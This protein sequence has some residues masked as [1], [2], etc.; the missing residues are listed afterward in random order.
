MVRLISA[1]LCAVL[2]GLT[3]AA[4]Q[5]YPSRPISIIV[6]YTPG[7]PVDQ[8]ARVVTEHMRATLGQPFVVENVSGA[9]GT[10]GVGRVAR[11]TPN[12]YTIG[13][14]DV[15]T[16]V[17]NGAVYPLSYDV[18]TDFEP[19]ALLVASPL[20]VL[21]RSSLPAKTLT[22]LV[23]WLKEN[24]ANVSQGFI[25]SGTLSHLC[26]LYLQQ[27]T[28]SKWT[29]VPYRGAAPA[30]QDLVG[31]QIDVMCLAPSGSSLPLARSGKIRAYAI[32]SPTR[33][34]SAKEIPTADEAGVPGLHLSFWQAL[35]VPKGTPKDI[36]DRLNAAAVVA[37]ADDGV[38]AKLTELG[39][40]IPARDQQTP[41]ALAALRRAEAD[42]W[43]PVIKAAGIKPDR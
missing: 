4:A 33:L 35:W 12:G 39:Q 20:L 38:R 43:W 15:G 34:P 11:A 5:P 17:L 9:G 31:G 37:L 23:A 25:G 8:V 14:G 1:T 29:F 40:I 24:R 19:V 13:I 26:G 6:P 21:S 27:V 16:Q 30:I 7:G 22:E 28:G 36:I 42:K 32:M 41:A 10:L 2:F 18:M 3:N